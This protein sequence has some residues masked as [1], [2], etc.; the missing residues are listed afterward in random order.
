MRVRLFLL[1]CSCWLL[2]LTTASTQSLHLRLLGVEASEV[3]PLER[4]DSLYR[5]SLSLAQALSDWLATRRNAGYL[6]ASV[7]TLLRVDTTYTALYHLGPAYEWF[8]LRAPTIPKQW[9]SRAGFR[10]RLF[11]NKPLA[12]AEW[13]ELQQ[14]IAQQAANNGFPF[15]KVSLDSIQWQSPGKVAATIQLERGSFIQFEQLELKGDAVIS[16][17]Y[18]LTYLGLR[19]GDPYNESTIQRVRQRLQELPFLKLKSA[20]QVQFIGNQARLQ[21]D[22]ARR[23]ASRF[24]FVVGVLPNSNQTGRLLVTAQLDG[25]LQNAFGKGER[26]AVDFEQLRPQTQA[27]ELAFSYPYLLQL[28][29]GLQTEL[30]LYR[31]DTNFLNLQ[32]QLGV[33]YLLRGGRR[34]EAFVSQQQTNLLGVDSVQLLTSGRLPDTLDVRRQAFGL[35]LELRQLDY[36]YNPRQGWEWQLRASAGQKTILTNTRV[37]ELGFGEL[38]EDLQLKSAQFRLETTAAWYQ[39]LGQRGVFK[40]GVRAAAILADE[41]VLIN[42]QFRIGG[43]RDLRGFDEES[44]FASRFGIL[45]GEYRFLLGT[46]SFLY[47][48][49]DAAYVDNAALSTPAEV[50]TTLWFQGFGAGITF[51]TRPGLFGLSLAFGKA[52]GGRFDLGAPKVHFGYVSLF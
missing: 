14:K 49:Y 20:P 11:Q 38:Y 10:A 24:D 21:L 30:Q 8:S 40:T 9:L 32:W 52:Q 36:R 5:D 35:G 26:I 2:S 33:D 31:R 25:A 3:R 4:P 42:E 47:A 39:P 34:V 51:E 18:L 29:F 37:E 12:L 22:L 15:A 44:V 23:S 13:Q 48:F 41:P 17:N 43:N 50:D 6:E 46:N 16:T 45:T 28:P 19:P 27:L 7:D 1:G